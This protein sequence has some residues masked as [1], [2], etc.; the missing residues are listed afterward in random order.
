MC[1]IKVKNSLIFEFEIVTGT[2]KY[3]LINIQRLNNRKI[4]AISFLD[5]TNVSKD[6]T[7]T[8]DM[9]PLAVVSSSY[10]V[11]TKTNQELVLDTFPVN[12]LIRNA[13]NPRVT[14]LE[15]KIY[16]TDKSYLLIPDAA[17]VAANNG[18][19]ITCVIYYDDVDS[20]C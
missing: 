20:N 6:S 14:E 16:D 12:D 9:A 3:K 17:L 15:P 4:L 13:D 2:S 19:V 7:G 11:M 10:L 1:Q 8:K 18:K 5:P